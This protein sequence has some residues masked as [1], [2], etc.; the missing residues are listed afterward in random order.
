MSRETKEPPSFKVF[1]DSVFASGKEIGAT[2]RL[3]KIG[4]QL[5]V[6]FPQRWESLLKVLW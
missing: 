6:Q 4:A 5:A 1:Y 2:S 3:V